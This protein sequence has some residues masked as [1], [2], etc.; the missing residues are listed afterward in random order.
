M[1]AQ[2][3]VNR[4]DI[5]SDV[6]YDVGD[7][8]LIFMLLGFLRP[9]V[10]KL[11]IVFVMLIGVTAVSLLPP[12]LI[13][14]AVDGPMTEGSVSG[15]LPYAILYILCVPVLFALR[16]GHIYLLQTVG[17]NA[18]AD[19]R[20][21]MFE[22]ILKQDMRFFNKTPVG[23]LVARL[24]SDIEALTELLSTSI[25]IVVSNLITLVG[26]IGV[27]FALNWRMAILGLAMLP[28]MAVS[29][30]YYRKRIRQETRTLHKLV[31]DY[32][33]FINEQAGGMLIVQLFGRQ[34]LSRQEFDT[35]NTEYLVVQN[36]VRDQ[37]TNFSS[38]L[39][40]LTTLGL[41][42]VLYGGAQGVAAG[43]AT[44][45]M[46][47]SFI[48]YTRRSFTP[49]LQLSEQFSQIQSA[50]SAGER[51]ARLLKTEPRILEAENPKP[52]QHVPHS[53][54]LENVEF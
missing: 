28:I 23:Q 40:V 39:Q 10:V 3:K 44:L 41:V 35:I 31:G 22:H 27:M 45:G 53:I 18:L 47:I 52:S 9:Y 43:W 37:Y 24:S 15:L 54:T 16:F 14:L 32:Q 51:I 1:T 48:E 17:Q 29:T 33:A 4:Q 36:K 42:I 6:S 50:L 20:Q 34:E 25:V 49:I 46:L 7:K 38:V 8:F 13:Q 19:L 30:L 26:I 12:Y 21:K 11:L 5:F 2:V